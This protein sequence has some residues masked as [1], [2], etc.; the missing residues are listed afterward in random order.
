MFSFFITNAFATVFSLCLPIKHFLFSTGYKIFFLLNDQ[1]IK[2]PSQVLPIFADTENLRTI[3]L[4][5]YAT[6][7]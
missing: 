1:E 6:M 2:I 3:N 7:L 4:D 5:S